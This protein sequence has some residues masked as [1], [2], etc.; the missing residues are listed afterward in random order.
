MTIAS[1]MGSLKDARG[2]FVRDTRAP[3]EHKGRDSLSFLYRYPLSIAIGI[4]T[5]RI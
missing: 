5:V 3:Q 2:R 1:A 4:F